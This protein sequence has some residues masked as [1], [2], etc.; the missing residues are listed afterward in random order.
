MAD[1]MGGGKKKKRGGG[2]GGGGQK[3]QSEK[4]KGG[5]GPAIEDAIEEVIEITEELDMGKEREENTTPRMPSNNQKGL[6]ETNSVCRTCW[7]VLCSCM[8]ASSRGG[9]GRGR[10]SNCG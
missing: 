3:I 2:G 1:A 8:L 5:P 6:F 7:L 4:P 9:G 10:R